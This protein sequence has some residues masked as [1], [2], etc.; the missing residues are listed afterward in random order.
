MIQVMETWLVADPANL[1]EFYGQGF[2]ENSLPKTL[3]LEHVPK[4]EIFARLDEA[5]AN[6]R[7]GRYHKIRHASD[8]LTRLDAGTVAHRCPACHRLLHTIGEI[9]TS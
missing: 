4:T 7:K 2:K 3:D 1:R 9:L 6:T 5:T 8:L